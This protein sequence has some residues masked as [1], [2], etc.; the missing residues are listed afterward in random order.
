MLGSVALQRVNDAIGFRPDGHSLEAKIVLRFAEAQRDLEKG[1]TLPKFL[2]QEDQTLTLL[3]GTR[4]VALPVGFLRESDESLIRYTPSG[5]DEPV[6]LTRRFL[7]DAINANIKNDDVPT[8]PKV[9][10][11][12]KSTINFVTAANITY[13][14]TWD[15]YKSAELFALNAENEWLANAPEWLIGECGYRMAMDLRDANAVGLFDKLRTTGRAAVFA[16][17][18]ADAEASGPYQMGANL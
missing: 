3:A 12:R 10:V 18:L 6:F 17:D 16:D 14:L 1:K 9:Y 7:I 15:Y 11:V 5:T 4:S 13:T 2:L 8:T